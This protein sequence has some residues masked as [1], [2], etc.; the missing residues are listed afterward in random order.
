MSSLPCRR[1]WLL[2]CR[3][4]RSPSFT[5]RFPAVVCFACWHWRHEQD[6]GV[7]FTDHLPSFVARRRFRSCP[8]RHPVLGTC[9]RLPYSAVLY[10]R[11]TAWRSNQCDSNRGGE[12]EARTHRRLLAK[13]PCAPAHSPCSSG[14]ACSTETGPCF[15]R[16]T[17]PIARATPPIPGGRDADIP[18]CA[19]SCGFLAWN[20]QFA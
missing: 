9:R 4:A 6:F 20:R 5:H 10:G 18:S 7:A 3:N 13:H 1:C 17:L 15:D 16:F 8:R 2:R 14:C 12:C 11:S 19:H